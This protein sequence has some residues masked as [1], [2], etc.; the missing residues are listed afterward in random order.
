MPVAGNAY[1]RLGKGT[2]DLKTRLAASL[3]GIWDD[4]LERHSFTR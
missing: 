1:L 3:A 2:R 4:K